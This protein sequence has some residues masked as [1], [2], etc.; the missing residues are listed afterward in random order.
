MLRYVLALVLVST[1]LFLG[2]CAT[3]SEQA[4]KDPKERLAAD[5]PSV[6]LLTMTLKNEFHPS[7]QPHM[8]VLSIEREG[9]TDAS[10]RF[11]FKADDL[12]KLDEADSPNGN[13][14]LLRIPLP[15]GNYEI[16]GVMASHRSFFPPIGGMFFAP[17]HEKL[18]V[19][20]GGAVYYLG[21]VEAVIRERQGEEFRAGPMIPLIDQAVVGAS[22]GTFDITISDHYDTDAALFQARFPVLKEATIQRTVLP[23][24]DRDEAQRWWQAH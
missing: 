21:H 10:G 17:L 3:P 11:N 7:Y 5:S 6:H 13:K 20:A 2:G 9:A 19:K 16:V 23:Q 18:E 15:P 12:G 24:F 4:L 14:Y 22:G 1:S 8:L